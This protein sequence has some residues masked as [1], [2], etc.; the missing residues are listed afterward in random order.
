MSSWWITPST[1][2]SSK[3]LRA[4][5]A[6]YARQGL[7]VR[8]WRFDAHPGLTATLTQAL[9][10]VDAASDYVMRLDND[11]R[12]DDCALRTLV[13]LAKTR[14]EI[15]VHGP[16][17]VHADCPQELQAG[18]IWINWY[19]GRD[20]MGDPEQ[21]VECDTLLGAV[22][23]FWLEALR[24][25]GRWFRPDLYLFSEE[26]EICHALRTLGYRTLTSH[27]Q[28]RCTLLEPA[29]GGGRRWRSTWSIGTPPSCTRKS[30][31]LGKHGRGYCGWCLIYLFGHGG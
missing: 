17:I 26:L 5:V 31:R 8:Y 21:P 3:S 28:R 30:P 18:A 4:A 25:L 1:D 15:S 7:R 14:R 19:G 27:L 13:D 23:L 12:L 9:A 24:R 29:P 10:W 11:V 6:A 16:R 20:R 22:M 2:G